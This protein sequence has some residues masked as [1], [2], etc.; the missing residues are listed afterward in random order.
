MLSWGVVLAFICMD[1]EAGRQT[2]N[3]LRDRHSGN[4]GEKSLNLPSISLLGKAATF[5]L[6]LIKDS[7]FQRLVHCP[8]KSR[9]MR[10]NLPEACSPCLFIYFGT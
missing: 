6:E 10:A 7:V 4:E 9:I 8:C 5:G 2:L 3:H 1:C